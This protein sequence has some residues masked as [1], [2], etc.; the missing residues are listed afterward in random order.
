M[1]SQNNSFGKRLL[2]RST[3]LAEASILCLASSSAFA[4]I[5]TSPVSNLAV[6]NTFDGVYINIVTGA[7]GTTGGATPGYD[8]NPY[9]A[10]TNLSI[11][12][13]ANATGGVGVT[14]ATGPLVNVAP[15]TTINGTLLYTKATAAT[16]PNFL[17]TGTEILGLQFLN[18]VTGVQNFGYAVLT[19]TAPNGF[20][21]TVV[22]I[23]YE[24]TG[25]AITVPAGGNTPPQFGYTPAVGGTV[26]FT[27]GT[28]IGSTGTGSIA[29]AVATPGSGS[30]AAATTTTTC[31]APTGAFAGFAQSVSA[32]GSGAITGSP[33]SGT[34]TLG[35]AVQTQ[36]LTCSENRGG[37]PTARTF[38]L[39][40]PAGT[41]VNTPPQ[42]TYTPPA[43]GTVSFT[44]GGAVGS[45]ATASI[46]AAVGTPGAGTG[47]AATT[48]TTCTAPTGAF[49]GFGQTVTAVGPGA[50]TGSPLS[51]SCTLGAAVQTQT[52][53]CS[54]NRGGTPT[55]VTFNLSCP[56][57]SVAAVTSNPPSGSPIAFGTIN[58][59]GT[60]TR[61]ITFTNTA[62]V[63]QTLTCTLTGGPFSG[64]TGTVTVPAGGSVTRT[65]NF[66]SAVIGAFTGNLSCTAGA[67]QFAFG[68]TGQAIISLTNVPTLGDG[69]RWLAILLM[70]GFGL[71]AVAV[72]RS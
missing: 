66:S 42:F 70:L 14:A 2:R 20:P 72:R 8:F 25:A 69:G 34:C 3:L 71:V 18:E 44:G 11:F 7:T 1:K 37:T 38:T 6:P 30:G 46:S 24:N 52:L 48:T 63:D 40:C 33:L 56:A 31:T 41:V 16:N 39:S 64:A 17:V 12:W 59:G 21:V 13:N 36:T 4:A 26:S 29:V 51:G 67:S 23:T 57:G 27:G 55:A 5:V 45:T 43:G 60:A 9:N 65:I 15:G 22:S 53:T 54:E 58:V 68:I 10:G 28:T 50:A 49:S 61:T 62:A 35:A 32:I 19:T 47:A